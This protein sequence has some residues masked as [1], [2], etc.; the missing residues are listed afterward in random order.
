MFLDS[1][2]L[3]GLQIISDKRSFIWI[4]AIHSRGLILLLSF[5]FIISLTDYALTV[6]DKLYI[7]WS[8]TVVFKQAQSDL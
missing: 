6:L 7:K 4:S 2:M 1:F 3:T 8:I 5:A